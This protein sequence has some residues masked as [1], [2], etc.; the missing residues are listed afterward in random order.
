MLFKSN[1]NNSIPKDK[2]IIKSKIE[3]IFKLLIDKRVEKSFS[4][5]GIY[6][7]RF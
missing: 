1:Y 7:I 3:I 4:Y 6:Y 2:K 5:I